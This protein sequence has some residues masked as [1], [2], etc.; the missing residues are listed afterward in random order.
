MHRRLGDAVS[1]A[2]LAAAVERDST[3]RTASI[4]HSGDLQRKLAT[5]EAE[6]QS[7]R[8]Q[9]AELNEDLAAKVPHASRTAGDSRANH[10]AVLLCT[11]R[12]WMCWVHTLRCG[13]WTKRPALQT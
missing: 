10:C 4:A 8:L 7:H 5:V 3:T 2:D 9:L 13:T 12:T 6:L 1:Q 11:R